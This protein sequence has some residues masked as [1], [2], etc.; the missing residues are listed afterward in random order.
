LRNLYPD[1]L[2]YASSNGLG[3]LV[4]GLTQR[5]GCGNIEESFSQESHDTRY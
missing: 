4:I 2:R 1:F 3:F 5:I